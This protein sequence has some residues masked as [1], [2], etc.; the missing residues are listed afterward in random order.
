MLHLYHKLTRRE[1][2]KSFPRFQNELEQ[3][4]PVI[5]DEYLSFKRQMEVEIRPIDEISND[6]AEL[7]Q[8]KKWKAAFLYAYN[9][10]NEKFLSFFPALQSLVRRYPEI[11]LM[12]FSTLESGKH[13]PPHVGRNHAVYRLQLGIHIPFPDQTE[14][15]VNQTRVQLKEG[16][17]FIF[18]DTFEHE[19]SNQSV[20]DRTVLIIDYEKTAIFPFNLLTKKYLGRISNSSYIQDAVKRW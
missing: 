16:E 7:N 1:Q 15:R 6:Q 12:M 19:A 2:P 3:A 14:L 4:F 11:K 18:D 13:I 5:R 17:I 8:D 20:A 9:Q 10:E